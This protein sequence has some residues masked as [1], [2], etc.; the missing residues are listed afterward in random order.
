MK[1]RVAAGAAVLVSVFL[2]TELILPGV[3]EDK[4]RDELR[5][6]A[7]VEAVDVDAFPALKLLLNR[8]DRVDVRLSEVTTGTRELAELLDSTRRTDVLRATV[9][10]VRMGPLLLRD[11]RLRKDG[12]RLDGEAAVTEQDLAAALPV[13]VGLRPVESE[14][15]ELVLEASGGGLAARARLSARDGALVIAPDG[16]LGAFASLTVFDDPRVRVT[17]VGARGR[18][19]GFTVTASGGLSAR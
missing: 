6:T 1:V 16:L 13:A 15:G 7:R 11:L 12:A 4:V 3:A 5:A 10:T 17:G 9:A 19:G 2:G 18:T 8:A 14:D